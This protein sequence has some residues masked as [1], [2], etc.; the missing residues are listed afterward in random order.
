MYRLISVNISKGTFFSHGKSQPILTNINRYLQYYKN[1]G[2]YRL[3]IF[4][5][6]KML[7]NI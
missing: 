5:N 2:L 1:I 7:S 4:M 3:S 6:E